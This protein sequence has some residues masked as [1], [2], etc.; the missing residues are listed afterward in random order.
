MAEV[1][2]KG[3]VPL[4]DRWIDVMDGE[5]VLEGGAPGDNGGG[6]RTGERDR[7]T[8]AGRGLRLAGVVHE[9][10]TYGPTGNERKAERLFDKTPPPAA[11]H[12]LVCARKPPGEAYPWTEIFLI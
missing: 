4:L 5:C 9:A 3:E 10:R 11:E 12:R 1:L 7:R 2:F 8:T 6:E